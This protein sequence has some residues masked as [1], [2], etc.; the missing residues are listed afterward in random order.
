M[1]TSATRMVGLALL[2]LA[3]PLSGQAHAGSGWT[4]VTTEDGIQVSM[5]DVPGRGFPTFRGRGVVQVHIFQV[6]AVISDV[7]RHP[8]WMYRCSKAKLLRK[9]DEMTRIIYGRTD[10]PWPVADRD[11]VFHSK[12]L[13]NPGKREVL[14]RF[15]AVK[16]ERMGEVKGVVRMQSLRGHYRLRALDTQRTYVEYQVDADPGGMIP[17]WLAKI[18]TKRLPLYTIQNLRK[19]V[20]KTSGW[21]HKRIRRWLAMYYPVGLA[22]RGAQAGK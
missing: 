9:V 2:A 22:A 8:E 7:G 13:V 4:H 17:T 21:Y 11:A 10:A 16:S 3:L 1:L 15:R 19:Q 12:A 6:V 5:R 20:R 18:A 14:L